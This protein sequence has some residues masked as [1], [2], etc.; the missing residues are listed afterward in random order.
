M[1]KKKPKFFCDF[2]GNEVKPN[3]KTCPK[4]GKF[5][6]SVRCPRCGKTG[7]QSDFLDGCPVCGYAFNSDDSESAS[8]KTSGHSKKRRNNHGRDSL[9]WWVFV[10]LLIIVLGLG[11]IALYKYR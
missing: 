5:F 9:P 8:S 1:E 3:A 7:K 11:V 2:C 4:C 6:E 10:I